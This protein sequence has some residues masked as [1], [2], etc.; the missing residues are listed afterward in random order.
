[1]WYINYIG[2]GEEDYLSL[3]ISSLRIALKGNFVFQIHQN[4]PSEYS[5][6]N[7]R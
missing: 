5:L 3:E 1:M 7:I 6:L 4:L 2:E